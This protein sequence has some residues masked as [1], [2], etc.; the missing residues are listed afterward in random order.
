MSGRNAW[1]AMPA[2]ERKGEGSRLGKYRG[3]WYVRRVAVRR[4]RPGGAVWRAC[5]YFVRR[6]DLKTGFGTYE[7]R[8]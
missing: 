6:P 2:R 1:P 5:L 8:A 3:N 4:V 7:E